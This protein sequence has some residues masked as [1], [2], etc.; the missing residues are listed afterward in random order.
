MPAS[1]RQIHKDIVKQ[2]HRGGHSSNQKHGKA[3]GLSAQSTCCCMAPWTFHSVHAEPR[4]CRMELS[5][6]TKWNCWRLDSTWVRSKFVSAMAHGCE[7][8]SVQT[9][10]HQS[11][12]S[13][14]VLLPTFRSTI[15]PGARSYCCCSRCNN[16]FWTAS[17]FQGNN[18]EINKKWF[19]FSP[20]SEEHKTRKTLD[21]PARLW[22]G[23]GLE[24]T[25]SSY[26]E[27]TLESSWKLCYFFIS[28]WWQKDQDLVTSRFN[29]LFYHFQSL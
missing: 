14:P 8:A 5:C 18:L 27:S 10:F 23:F 6:Q 2:S 11:C 19:E 20:Y 13:S 12:W 17:N 26:N 25:R 21:S 15:G 7:P 4:T 3:G 9:R 22:N 1:Y 28:W 29:L 16:S 24:S